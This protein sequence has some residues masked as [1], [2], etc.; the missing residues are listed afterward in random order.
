ME[1]GVIFSAIKFH[2]FNIHPFS[3]GQEL[4]FVARG[5]EVDVGQQQDVSVISGTV[6]CETSRLKITKPQTGNIAEPLILEDTIFFFLSSA[7][8]IVRVVIDSR[9]A[10]PG[11]CGWGMVIVAFFFNCRVDINK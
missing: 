8:L 5:R 10:I 11:G 9:H 4:C 7:S 2:P 3:A 6:K 1:K